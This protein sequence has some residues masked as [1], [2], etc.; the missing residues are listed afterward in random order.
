[1]Q[2]VDIRL[3]FNDFTS[4]SQ[5]GSST[6]AFLF[7]FQRELADRLFGGSASSVAGG[8]PGQPVLL[9]RGQARVVREP[10]LGKGEIKPR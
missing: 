1:M 2:L 7:L 9:E 3:F 6:I 5:A 10:E 8:V 4:C